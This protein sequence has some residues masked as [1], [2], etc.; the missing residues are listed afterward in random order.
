VRKKS[1]KQAF[2]LIHS[3]V[4]L[5]DFQIEFS[6]FTN[7]FFNFSNKSQSLHSW[8]MHHIVIMIG[9]LYINPPI[10]SYYYLPYKVL[11][12]IK[13]KTAFMNFCITYINGFVSKMCNQYLSCMCIN[14][15]F[16]IP[17]YHDPNLIRAW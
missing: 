17:L 7:K 8:F 6:N 5:P 4:Y 15:V 1:I 3:T 12:I 10:F 9:F 2:Y 14:T 11:P 13:K 16:Y